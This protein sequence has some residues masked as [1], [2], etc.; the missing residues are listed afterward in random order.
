M[1]GRW[2]V[3]VI[4]NDREVRQSGCQHFVFAEVA[5]PRSDELVVRLGG[6]EELSELLLGAGQVVPVRRV[7]FHE[8]LH[9]LEDAQ[10]HF[11][12]RLAQRL[13]ELVEVAVAD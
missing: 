4:S 3:Q 6:R 11:E 2:V 7:A 10:P 8:A 13:V 9:P 12:I 5:V 1:S